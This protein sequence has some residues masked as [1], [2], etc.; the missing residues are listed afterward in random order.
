MDTKYLISNDGRRLPAGGPLKAEYYGP[1]WEIARPG[2]PQAPVVI[3]PDPG[4]GTAR[5]LAARILAM[6]E[7]DGFAG[8][9]DVDQGH[10]C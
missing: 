5:P 4:D 10:L 1:A 6:L 3:I 8:R 7:V 2:R 9:E